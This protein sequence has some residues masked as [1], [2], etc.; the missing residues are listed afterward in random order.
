[1]FMS[2]E[3]HAFKEQ[4]GWLAKK[5]TPFKGEVGVELIFTF[6]DK[7]RRDSQNLEK[8][9][10]DSLEGYCYVND[11]QIAERKIKRVYGDRAETYIKIYELNK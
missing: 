3:G 8:L 9:L 11:S 7:R 2:S 5:F 4:M 1:M 10:Y 6:P